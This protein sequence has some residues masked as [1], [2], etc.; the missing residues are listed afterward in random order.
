MCSCI[1]ALVMEE[2][3]PYTKISPA[4]VSERQSVGAIMGTVFL[5]VSIVALLSVLMWYRHKR[6]DKGHEM[7]SVLYT[8]A[9]HV[10][11]TDYS[12]SGQCVCLC[13]CVCVC[14]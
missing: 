2:L 4:L 13:V 6:Q 14:V 3:N 7:P 5:L 10:S 9:M 8:P 12:L 1:A 11:T